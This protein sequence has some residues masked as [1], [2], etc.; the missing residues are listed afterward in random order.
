METYISP[1]W[2]GRILCLCGIRGIEGT[3]IGLRANNGLV[4]MPME[5]EGML[6]RI[7]IKSAAVQEDLDLNDK[8]ILFTTM[9][10]IYIVTGVSFH[11]LREHLVDLFMKDD[12]EADKSRTKQGG[13]L[14]T[15]LVMLQYKRMGKLSIN[16]WV[17]SVFTR[18]H[19][20]I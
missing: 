15:Y 14:I 4:G 19:C 16:Q 18:A 17:S 3:S 5:M 12:L 11:S 7:C 6:P 2:N 20:S 10:M 1:H 8:P 9:S 13:T